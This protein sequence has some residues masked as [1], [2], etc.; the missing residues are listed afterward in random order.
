MRW[1]ARSAR[2]EALAGSAVA[3]VLGPPTARA[4]GQ[5]GQGFGAPK[6]LRWGPGAPTPSARSDGASCSL[7]APQPTQE[8]LCYAGK[9][10]ALGRRSAEPGHRPS[11]WV[12]SVPSVLLPSG[13]TP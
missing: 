13:R 2:A 12:T 5:P 9:A 4:P 8:P 1:C 3:P 11:A 10:A 7:P 6:A